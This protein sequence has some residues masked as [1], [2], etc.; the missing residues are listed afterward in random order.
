MATAV[1]LYH[2]YWYTINMLIMSL[3]AFY[4]I[5]NIYIHLYIITQ[6]LLLFSSTVFIIKAYHTFIEKTGLEKY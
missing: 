5:Y 4:F 3:M 1:Y 2:V 6:S